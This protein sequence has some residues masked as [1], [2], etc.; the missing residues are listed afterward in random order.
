MNVPL[1]SHGMARGLAAYTNE[2][3]L[4]RQVTL[5]LGFQDNH[6]NIIFASL[7]TQA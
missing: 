5:I 6:I 4:E 1:F 7:R 3:L 2:N